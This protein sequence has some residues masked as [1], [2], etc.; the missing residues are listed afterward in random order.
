[1]DMNLS[2]DGVGSMTK[3]AGK[4]SAVEQKRIRILAEAIDIIRSPN[5]SRARKAIASSVIPTD[6][7]RTLD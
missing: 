6:P 4:I 2:Q 3:E 5:A 7:N 1:M